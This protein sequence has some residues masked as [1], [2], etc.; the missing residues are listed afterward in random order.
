MMDESG[1]SPCASTTPAATF[2]EINVFSPQTGLFNWT[3]G[4]EHETLMPHNNFKI[5]QHTSV[6]PILAGPRLNS[7][8]IVE[9]DVRLDGSVPKVSPSPTM[10]SMATTIW[11]VELGLPGPSSMPGKLGTC[12]FL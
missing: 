2:N 10:P 3:F 1:G 6:P 8:N 9:D 5:F 4:G 11:S 12:T 7:D